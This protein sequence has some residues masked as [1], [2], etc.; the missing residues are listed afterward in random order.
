V[1]VE[2]DDAA[3]PLLD[4]R[5]TRRL[6]ALE[7]ADIDVALPGGSKQASAPLFFRVVRVEQNL[8]V[9]LWV[10]GEYHGARLISGS[11]ALGQLGARRVALAAAELARRLQKRRQIQAARERALALANAARAAREARRALDGP[12]A[13]RPSL[14]L[15]EIGDRSATLI[16]SRLLG[17]WTFVRRT[18]LDLG[19]AWFAGAA[20]DRAWA[21]WAELSVAP[22]QRL[23]IAETLDLDLGLTLA[24]AWLRFS[25]VRG[26]DA[27]ADQHETWSA[28][29][30]AVAR[31]EPR[32]SRRL[33]LSIGAEAGLV[34]REI[35]FQPMSGGADRLRGMWLSLGLG[36]V[37]TPR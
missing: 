28:R 10:R 19:L 37:F 34:L 5:A 9:E 33:R 16:G 20:P 13:V 7:L 6:V 32:L 25:R 24:A 35:P 31:L 17:Q 1:L 3:E 36:V 30:A 18:R 29:A 15:A 27:I 14:E 11:N 23:A 26:V 2:L 12:L 22:M 8:R 21:E 4:A